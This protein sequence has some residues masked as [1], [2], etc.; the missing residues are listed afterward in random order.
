MIVG[1]TGTPYANGC[2]EFD[3]FF[4]ANYPNVPM[5]INLETNGNKKVGLGLVWLCWSE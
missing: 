3:V 2:F 1:P 5:K 4:P